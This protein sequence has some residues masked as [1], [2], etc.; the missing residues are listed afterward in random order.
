MCPYIRTSYAVS[1][2]HLESRRWPVIKYYVDRGYSG[3]NF[4]R[5]AM[6]E[7]LA[8]AK[9][10]IIDLILVKDLSR[11]GRNHLLVGA[12]IETILP[13]ME[14]RF[15]APNNHIDTVD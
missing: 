15:I 2:T 3:A 8:D 6:Q 10:G 12:L 7:M 11:I 4:E 14:C 1:Y 5:P 9:E 13:E